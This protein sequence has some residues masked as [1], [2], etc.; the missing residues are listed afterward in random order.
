MGKYLTREL[1]LP[2]SSLKHISCYTGFQNLSTFLLLCKSGLMLK[3]TAMIRNNFLRQRPMCTHNSIC[4]L[5]FFSL[6]SLGL[7]PA[8]CVATTS[9]LR[10]PAWACEVTQE[11]GEAFLPVPQTHPG[12]TEDLWSH[13]PNDRLSPWLIFIIS[14]RLTNF[15]WIKPRGIKETLPREGNSLSGLCMEW[16]KGWP[17]L[18]VTAI[19]EWGDIRLP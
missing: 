5:F 7:C 16:G 1:P 17:A 18:E 11:M 4:W 19:P 12:H 15:V 10:H 13:L 14:W 6:R 9:W 8:G 3:W 2:F